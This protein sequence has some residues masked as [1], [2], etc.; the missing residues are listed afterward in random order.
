MISLLLYTNEVTNGSILPC[1]EIVE[2]IPVLGLKTFIGTS[3]GINA[4]TRASGMEGGSAYPGYLWRG[5]QYSRE[6]AV[7]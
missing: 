2:A 3:F 1:S 6:L 4:W 7:V 5:A